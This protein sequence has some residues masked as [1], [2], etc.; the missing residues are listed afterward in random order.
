MT[1]TIDILQRDIDPQAAVLIDLDTAKFIPADAR[2]IS[3]ILKAAGLV[4]AERIKGSS[5][6]Y[7]YGFHVSSNDLSI[8]RV[9]SYEDEGALELINQCV[10]VLRDKGFV[11]VSYYDKAISA[12]STVSVFKPVT[13]PDDEALF[14]MN[15]RSGAYVQQDSTLVQAWKVPAFQA[16]RKAI[17]KRAADT[18]ARI[19][20]QEEA[21]RQ[22]AENLRTN[23]EK[24][25]LP[26]SVHGN[27]IH[28]HAGQLNAWLQSQGVHLGKI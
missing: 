9:S 10:R 26:C 27:W 17:N 25:G 13:T 7:T 14:W 22:H 23:L 5:G 21:D 15:L 19:K 8:F 4:R 18:A 11:V 1:I 6:A 20:A 12:Y 24:A 28:V 16:E 3:R 2:H